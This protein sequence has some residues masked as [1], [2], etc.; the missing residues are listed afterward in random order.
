MLYCII[1][2]IFSYLIHID[3]FVRF[4]NAN[5]LPRRRVK[6]YT[7][8]CKKMSCS[9]INY[10]FHREIMHLQKPVWC[11]CSCTPSLPLHMPGPN[12]SKN[13]T[14][15]KWNTKRPPDMPQLNLVPSPSSTAAITTR[16][17]QI[18]RLAREGRHGFVIMKTLKRKI[19]TLANKVR[20]WLLWWAHVSL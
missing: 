11:Q 12:Q 4:L 20:D 15:M 3:C 9:P 6:S 2:F 1:I 5:A 19:D 7:I 13:S 16:G 17:Y 10:P 14:T 8:K 18:H